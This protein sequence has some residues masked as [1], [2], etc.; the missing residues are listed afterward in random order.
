MKNHNYSKIIEKLNIIENDFIFTKI[1]IMD[2]LKIDNI[3]GHKKDSYTSLTFLMQL[4]E[5]KK[6]TNSINSFRFIFEF[7]KNKENEQEIIINIMFKSAF[8]TKINK[9]LNLEINKYT[10][11]IEFINDDDFIL[12]YNI[13]TKEKI[14]ELIGNILLF[15]LKPSIFINGILNFKNNFIDNYKLI[16]IDNYWY[17]AT[18]FFRCLYITGY[19]SSKL[20]LL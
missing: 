14:E 20:S 2:I 8:Y 10:N 17:A 1:P 19:F 15:C 16:K 3:L 4:E 7:Y 9:Y 5:I 12:K 11:L 13:E 18:S 6:I